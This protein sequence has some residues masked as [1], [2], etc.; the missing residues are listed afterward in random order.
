MMAMVTP[1]TSGVMVMSNSFGA[2]GRAPDPTDRFNP[3]GRA[4]D[5]PGAAV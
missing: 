3:Y 1:Q 5:Q 2:A 4:A